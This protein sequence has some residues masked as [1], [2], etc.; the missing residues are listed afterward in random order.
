MKKNKLSMMAIVVI[1]TMAYAP[2]SF[3]AVSPEE[4]AKLGTTLTLF[5]A[6]KAGNKDG[7]IPA[8]TGGL[9]KPPANYVPNS[10]RRP[11]PFAGEKPL[12]SIN[13][14]NMSQY[15]DKLTE[16]TKGLMKKYPTYRIDVFKTHRTVAYPDLV[17]K[18]T[19][20]LATKARTA[21]DG[22]ILKDAHG[23]FPF[24]IPK[25]PYEVMWN[26]LVRYQGRSSE[27]R[28]VSNLVDA[29]GRVVPAAGITIW[30][31]WPYYDEDLTRD[32]VKNGIFWK[33]RWIFHAPARK[34]GEAGQAFDPVNMALPP[35]RVAHQYLPGQRRTKLA[36]QI[37]F[38]T[39]STDACGEWTYDETWVYN[40]S[41]ERYNWKLVGKK[42]MYVPY[43]TWQPI[44]PQR[45]NSTKH[46]MLTRIACAGSCT[47]FG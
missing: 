26:H 5:G 39:P 9:T 18:N 10:G 8:Y 45:M 41:M 21:S 15:A 22:L 23:G 28:A 37:A 19:V 44:H 4:A 13:A 1:L 3:G 12:F 7:T 30:Q 42:E 14:Q 36:P 16:G 17:L 24:P 47:G 46:H 38:D 43:N 27:S 2:L 29:T 11:D 31:E 20:K 32:D 40:G 6:E 34:A 33:I 25:T 35:G